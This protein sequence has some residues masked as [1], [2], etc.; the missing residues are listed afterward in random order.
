VLIQTSTPSNDLY[1]LEHNPDMTHLGY[2]FNCR[3][4]LRAL[5]RLVRATTCGLG[6]ACDFR[7]SHFGGRAAKLNR[8]ECPSHQFLRCACHLIAAVAYA[9]SKRGGAPRNAGGP[10]VAERKCASDV[11]TLTALWALLG[12]NANG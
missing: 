11:E 5:I 7:R 9:I 1:H 8:M 3:S 4:N 6:S 2:G 10:R 12:T